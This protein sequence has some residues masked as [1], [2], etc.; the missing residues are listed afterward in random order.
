MHE[1]FILEM[2][3][4]SIPNLSIKHTLLENNTASHS[5]VSSNKAPLMMTELD[6]STTTESQPKECSHTR[7]ACCCCMFSTVLQAHHS[8]KYYRAGLNAI[9]HKG[10]FRWFKLSE[11][12]QKPQEIRFLVLIEHQDLCH[13]NLKII[14]LLCNQICMTWHPEATG[15][16]TQC[17]TSLRSRLSYCVKL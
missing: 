11:I 4:Q 12:K 8:T 13:Q 9:K 6:S 7:V 17:V 15:T 1:F 3:Q 14:W 16:M 10:V 5:L 2:A